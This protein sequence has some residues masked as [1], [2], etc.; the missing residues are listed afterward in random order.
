MDITTTQS[1]L[2]V[3]LCY[4]DNVKTSWFL[5][6]FFHCHRMELFKIGHFIFILY[7]LWNE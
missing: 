4:V 1:F 5:V 2:E 7:F 3:K 6:N